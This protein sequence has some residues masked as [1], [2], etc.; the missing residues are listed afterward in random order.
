MALKSYD[1]LQWNCRGLRG[2]YETNVFSPQ[3]ISPVLVLVCF[4]ETS[5]KNGK[6]PSFSRSI[7]Y[8]GHYTYSGPL[9]IKFFGVQLNIV[10]RYVLFKYPL[11]Y[12]LKMM[13]FNNYHLQFCYLETLMVQTLNGVLPHLVFSEYI[14][15]HGLYTYSG[16]LQ[17]KLLGY[18][19]IQMLRY[20]LFEYPFPKYPLKMTYFINYHLQFC[21]LETLMV[22]TLNGVLHH[23]VY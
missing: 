13:Y 21:Y 10:L 18:S 20:V 16:S 6:A 22:Q 3:S 17:I 11:K 4:Y 14:C 15:Y 7:C 19:S 9:Q 8:H 1:T 12:S 5:L 23:L 2:N